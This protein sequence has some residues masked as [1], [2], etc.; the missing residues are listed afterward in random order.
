LDKLGFLFKD[1]QYHRFILPYKVNDL[2]LRQKAS[3]Y[4]SNLDFPKDSVNIEKLFSP[5]LYDNE[6]PTFMVS[7]R[8]GY[9]RQMIDSKQASQELF[10]EKSSVLLAI[11]NVYYRTF[12]HQHMLRSPARIIWYVS[13]NQARLIGMSYLDEILSDTPKELFKRLNMHGVFEWRDI[14]ELAG[15]NLE[16]KVMALKFSM[17]VTFPNDVL[18]NTLL[19]VCQNHNFNLALPSPTRIPMPALTEIFDHAFHRK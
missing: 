12:S 4:I 16:Q 7:I 18:R 3:T 1:E 2:T 11:E 5:A 10:A 17:T 14:F 9:A 15:K 8:E 19:E 6:I 13:G